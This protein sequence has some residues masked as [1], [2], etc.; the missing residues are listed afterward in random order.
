MRAHIIRQKPVS[1]R[2]YSRSISPPPAVSTFGWVIFFSP[3]PVYWKVSTGTG[4]EQ[5]ILFFFFVLLYRIN[6]CHLR[7]TKF[8]ITCLHIMI[9]FSIRLF[10]SY[11]FAF[12]FI[13]HNNYKTNICVC[14]CVC[15]ICQCLTCDRSKNI[16][17]THSFHMI[18]AG[19]QLIRVAIFPFLSIKTLTHV[20]RIRSKFLG[21]KH[22]D[23]Q[24]SFVLYIYRKKTIY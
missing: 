21:F 16:R 19:I 13:L 24:D 1:S 6:Y 9:Q 18:F 12:L 8:I 14:V 23:E 10:Y 20:S 17:I 3:Q 2:L 15:V 4:F 11:R 7:P 22:L 5:F